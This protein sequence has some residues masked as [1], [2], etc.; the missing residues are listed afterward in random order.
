MSDSRGLHTIKCDKCY[1]TGIIENDEVG[2]F[3]CSQCK[4]K[5]YLIEDIDEEKE[6]YYG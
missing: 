1:G 2:V 3:K 5:S 6:A 4:G